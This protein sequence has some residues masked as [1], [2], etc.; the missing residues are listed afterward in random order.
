[1]WIKTIQSTDHSSHSSYHYTTPHCLSPVWSLACFHPPVA[2]PMPSFIPRPPGKRRK[3]ASKKKKWGVGWAQRASCHA[4]IF[5]F[6]HG[7]CCVSSPEAIHQPPLGLHL[8]L[9]N[10]FPPHNTTTK[11][12]AKWQTWRRCTEWQRV[13][14]RGG[15]L[16]NMEE[17]MWTE[18][19]FTLQWIK[20]FSCISGCLA[21]K[22]GEGVDVMAGCHVGSFRAS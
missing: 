9:P 1:M 6:S 8:T 5:T 17:L 3:A 18:F 4:Y 2:P 12:W 15:W 11:P 13:T 14:G 20:T 19:T 16:F 7:L 21:V 22:L 10:S